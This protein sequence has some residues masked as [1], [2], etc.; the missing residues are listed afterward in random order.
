LIAP[1]AILLAALALVVVVA[2]SLDLDG[3]GPAAAPDAGAAEIQEDPVAAGFGR[4]YEVQLG[5]S[6]ST[7]AE[8][9]GVPIDVLSQLNPDLDP[10]TLNPGD[11]VKLR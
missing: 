8:E 3:A 9:T 5:D 11:R 6:L 7:I 2:T 1:L 10:Q 4:N